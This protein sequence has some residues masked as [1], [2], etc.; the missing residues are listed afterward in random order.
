MSLWVPEIHRHV[1]N[2]GHLE[3][4]RLVS[5]R[6]LGLEAAALRQQLV[7]SSGNNP[8]LH[9][10][11]STDF[12]GVAPRR[13]WIGWAGALIIMKPETV[14]SWH[15]ARLPLFWRLHSR[16]LGRQRL[17][18]EI[19]LLIRRMKTVGTE[20][21]KFYSRAY[22]AAGSARATCAQNSSKDLRG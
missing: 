5:Q 8:D 1:L 16:P 22:V 2:D 14:V 6:R 12:S 15:R 4:G 17:S 9:Y 10:A 3:V 18:G 21:S 13:L 20:N 7:L 11:T 19:R